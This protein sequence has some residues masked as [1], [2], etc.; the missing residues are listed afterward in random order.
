MTFL[1][2]RKWTKISLLDN[3]FTTYY[4]KT[5]YETLK[6]EGTDILKKQTLKKEIAYLYEY[7]FTY[8]SEDV[9]KSEWSYSNAVKKPILI[10]HY[11]N[12]EFE[13]GEYLPT[14]VDYDNLKNNNEFRNM[15]S[16]S[17][18]LRSWNVKTTKKVKQETEF[19]IKNIEQELIRRNIN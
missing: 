2:I 4:T 18:S 16:K 17:I 14:P 15:L 13:N 9:D 6:T 11:R 10:E 8:L 3:W 5:A 1:V 19:L 7:T 12:Y